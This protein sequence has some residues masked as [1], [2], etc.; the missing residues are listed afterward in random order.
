MK[1]LFLISFC[2]SCVLLS[3]CAMNFPQ[4]TPSCIEHKINEEKSEYCDGAVVKQ[5]KFNGRDVFVFET[6]TCYADGGAQVLDAE[7]NTVCL[8][9][10]IAGLTDCEG[11]DFEDN[12]EYL[13][14]IW[15]K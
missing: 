11:I 3:S 5:Y 4:G 2:V 7:C 6:Q 15:V 13:K 9:G 8:L 10:G 14:T 12:A 1:N